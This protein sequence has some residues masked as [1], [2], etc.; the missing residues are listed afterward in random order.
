MSGILLVA[1][2]GLLVT[3]HAA[4]AEDE[5]VLRNPLPGT[6]NATAM[7]FFASNGTMIVTMGRY[8]SC[9]TS[10]DGVQ[11]TYRSP[12]LVGDFGIPTGHAGTA[13]NSIT[14]GGHNFV[15]VG[16]MGI[17]TSPDG[18]IWSTMPFSATGPIDTTL[19]AVA[20]GGS[21]YVAVGMSGGIF[22]SP[23]GL[24]WTKQKS[25]TNV[26]LDD[27]L[28]DGKQFVVVGWDGRILTSPDGATWA[29]QTL[30]STLHF[31]GIAWNGTQYVVVGPAKIYSSLDGVTWITRNPVEGGS[32]S[33]IAWS[34]TE[35]VIFNDGDFLISPDGV[36]WTKATS[37]KEILAGVTHWS[38]PIWRISGD[39]ASY[40]TAPNGLTKLPVVANA[41]ITA[42]LNALAWNGSQFVAVG[43]SGA[44]M[45]SPDGVKW[46]SH[47][48]DPSKTFVAI[49]WNGTQFVAIGL[50]GAVQ[51]STDGLTWTDRASGSTQ[52]LAGLAWSGK[53]YVAVGTGGAILTSPDGSVWTSR[54]S[55]VDSALNSVVWAGT[56][57]VAVGDIGT[58]LVSP[59]G[60]SW[61]CCNPGTNYDIHAIAWNGK[62]LVAAVADGRSHLPAGIISSFPST[63]TD[64]LAS[65]DGMAWTKWASIKSVTRE[66]PNGNIISNLIWTGTQFIGVGSCGVVT[67]PNG[68]DWTLQDKIPVGNFNAVASNG[69]QNVAVGMGGA[70]ISTQPQTKAL[71]P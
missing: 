25:G 71:T 15:A 65:S 56:Q 44:V 57:F 4:M 60:V 11:W 58:V 10:P 24:V 21:H 6:G 7:T 47:R 59:D 51:T 52:N 68:Y 19:I 13:I 62:N 61:T 35:F 64:F 45:T 30:G 63:G 37:A 18:I 36:T 48:I 22:S 69:T 28:W 27:V 26:P 41:T 17:R 33:H 32:F 29:S 20:W 42:S 2:F 31:N 1:M 3:T 70:I 67:S 16:R 9:A 55:G 40:L 43:Y 66:T 23:D 50:K 38:G 34:G 54:V 46:S 12:D 49:L 5:W 39:D 53:Q 14:W 8:G